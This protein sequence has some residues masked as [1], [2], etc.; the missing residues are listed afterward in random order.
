MEQRHALA[1]SQ[2]DK[3]FEKTISSRPRYEPLK[4]ESMGESSMRI[5]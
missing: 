3:S 5:S 2:L 1:V 4:D